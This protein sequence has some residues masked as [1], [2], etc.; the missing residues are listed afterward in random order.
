[1]HGR[2]AARRHHL[3][4]FAVVFLIM[5]PAILVPAAARAD[6]F[7][8]SSGGH[9][10]CVTTP[11]S[12]LSGEVTVTVTNSPN[13]GSVFATWIPSGGK[14]TRLI[15][16]DAPSPATSDYT[17]V[18]PTQK[19]LNA[20]G[21]LRLQAGSTGATAVDV[22]ATLSNGDY[23][24]PN[25]W[26]P[27][28][29][30]TGSNDPTVLAVGDGPSNELKS[31]Q[32]AA[33]I[34][35]APRPALFLFLGDVYETGTFTEFRNHYGVSALDAPGAGTLWGATADITQPTLGNHENANKTA[36]TDYWHGRPLFT[37][38]TF[39][40]T[41]FLDMNSSAS[42][43][44]TSAQ[45]QFVRSA[46]AD[47]SAPACIVA[48]WHIPAVTSNTGLT[49]GQTA[50]WSLL[51]NNGVDLLMTA[52]LH[53]MIEFKPLDASFT[54]GTPQSHLV[55]LVDGAGG[56]K[57]AGASGVP[58]GDRIAW[59]KGSTAGPV[60]LTL[61]GAANGG[62][63]SS[64]GWQFQDVNGSALPGGSG[65]VDCQKENRPPVVDAGPDQEIV[66]PTNQATMHG[67]VTDDGLPNPPG[68]VTS[69]WSQVSGPGTATFTEPSS[70]TTTVSFDDAPGTYVLQ[71]KGDDGALQTTDDVT[72]TVRPEGTVVLDV[73]VAVSSN[74]AEESSAGV[75][76]RASTKLE[77]VVDAGDPQTV[78]MRFAVLGIPTGATIQEAHVQFEVAKVTTGPCSL[79]IQGQA[80]DNPTT[81]TTAA[82]NISSRPR[83]SASV[84][85]APAPWPTIQV[86]GPDQRTPDLSSV[87][88]EIVNRA[89]WASGNAMV[90]I[91]TG[92]GT[93][94]A[95]SFDG[96]FAPILH[97]EYTP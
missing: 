86:H 12:P 15:E 32:V 44:A 24:S 79:T 55:E 90:V 33:R 74:D 49:S 96:T 94:T 51:A 84:G 2:A 88:Q 69:T 35:T 29:P 65:S 61:N 66:L 70:P 21:T 58:P 67:S 59:S 81:F 73:P 39:G 48:Y 31:N 52:H 3:M 37:K 20:D 42:M 22:A 14:T 56:H 87:V 13:S 50:I 6:P 75:V 5:T 4:R 63:A 7:C 91:I 26:A 72:I 17:F 62:A 41:L 34:A 85:W 92:S 19:Y 64:I 47:P 40:G 23:Q 38:F 83:T 68:K 1:M 16:M 30:W 45:Y 11:A 46:V 76:S 78:G 43:S 28:A 60:A 53:K 57:L 54:A 18:W 25:D 36:Y 71:L 97:I 82:F 93:R 89:G 27:P 8:G 95:E 10:L 9:T 80:A 77:L